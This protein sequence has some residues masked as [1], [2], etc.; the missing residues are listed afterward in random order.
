MIAVVSDTHLPRG[1]RRLPD[2]CVRTLRDAGLIVHA[3]DFTSLSALRDLE[4]FGPVV[5]VHG[6]M[7]DAAVRA[8]LPEREVVDSEGLCIGIVHD[9]GSAAGRHERLR[10][11]FPACDAI[12]YGHSHAPEIARAGG[13]WIL[14]PGSPTERR[15]SPARTMIVITDGVPALVSL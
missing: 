15:R 8:R 5:G 7:D 6:N 3:G 13:T 14:N 9:G 1:S 2:G 10:S 11:W 12:V 4:T